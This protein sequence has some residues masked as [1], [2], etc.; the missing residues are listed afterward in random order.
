MRSRQDDLDPMAD[1]AN[2][3]N[4]GL[5][6]F[7]DVMRFAGNLLGARQQGFGLADRDD[8]GSPL[9]PGNQTVDQVALHGRVFIE[10]GVA[11]RLANLLDHHLL[12]ALSGDPAQVGGIDL[13]LPLLDGDLARIAID[14]HD[15]AGLLAVLL[16]AG[17]Q[18]GIFDALEDDVAIDVLLVVHLIHDTQEVGTLHHNVFP[19]NIA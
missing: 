4:D 18:H 1:L 13:L 16:L 17:Q 14:G 5:D 7:A 9:M 6:A 12:G 11:L 8:A 15:H 10:D 3:E 19:S 2:V